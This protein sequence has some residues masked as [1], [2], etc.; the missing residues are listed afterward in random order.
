MKYYI[1]FSQ[2]RS[3]S[4]LLSS[5][6]TQ[7]G[8]GKP[9]EYF[10]WMI[11][12]KSEH[13]RGN[14]PLSELGKKG[15]NNDI[16]GT[17]CHWKHYHPAIKKLKQISGMRSLD[18]FQLLNA[19]FPNVQFI[20]LKRLHTIKQA[21]SWVQANNSGD[22]FSAEKSDVGEYSTQRITEMI[23]KISIGESKLL[24]LTE[25][26]NI[27]PH[28]VTYEDLCVRPA[29]VLQGILDFL[30]VSV[31]TNEP[32]EEYIQKAELPIQQ[33]NTTSENWYQRYLNE[34]SRK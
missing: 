22:Y 17:I 11:H 33:Y 10:Y 25:K 18:H 4:H 29:K 14:H 34:M 12:L 13:L 1:V 7:L 6:L 26:Y 3:G 31:L 2:P 15:T 21:L 8:V 28:V 9:D 23:L 20:Y 16:W 5:Y 32:F 27:E 30:G 19:V 24:D